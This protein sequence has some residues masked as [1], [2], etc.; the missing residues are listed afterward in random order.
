[1]VVDGEETPRVSER[2]H[3]LQPDRTI[4]LRGFD[5]LG[6]AAAMHSATAQ[7]FT[8]SGV[9]RDAADFAEIGRASCRVR[10]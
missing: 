5:H 6:A 1:M 10:V 2:I 3:K 8:V 7:G 9:F 4:Q